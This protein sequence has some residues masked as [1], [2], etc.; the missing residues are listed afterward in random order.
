MGALVHKKTV[1]TLGLTAM[2]AFPV[3]FVCKDFK[4]IGAFDWKTLENQVKNTGCQKKRA[5][6]LELGGR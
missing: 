2:G 3:F 5:D 6:Q 4:T 1:F